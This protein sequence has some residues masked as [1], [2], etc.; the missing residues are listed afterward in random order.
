M[1]QMITFR[2]SAERVVAIDAVVAS[3]IFPSRAS[4]IVA[5]IDR[6]VADLERDAVDRAIV[7]G[8]SR[9]PPTQAESTRATVAGR[10]S[11]AAEPW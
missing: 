1:S 6:L 8:Y 11:I 7:G 4:L 3:G 9:Q 2:T 5:A 10:R